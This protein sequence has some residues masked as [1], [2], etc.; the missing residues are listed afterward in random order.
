L[1][2]KIPVEKM[3]AISEI[4]STLIASIIAITLILTA[5]LTDIDLVKLDLAFLDRIE[6]NEI[7]DIITGLILIFMGLA[8]DVFL[9]ARRRQSY[10]EIQEQRLRVLKATMTTVQDIVNNFLNNLRLFRMEAEGALPE[11][12][13]TAFDKLIDQTSA[14]LKALGDMD[15]TPEKQMAIGIGIDLPPRQK[16]SDG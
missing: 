12:S 11:E 14:Q 1:K 8:V 15:S 2:Q 13:L 5:T 7:D 16:P 3:K 10:A 9:A 6:K 4:R